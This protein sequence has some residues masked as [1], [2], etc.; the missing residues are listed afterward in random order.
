MFFCYQD[1]SNLGREKRYYRD[2]KRGCF[3]ETQMMRLDKKMDGQNP[4]HKILKNDY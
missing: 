3:I 4:I 2:L 1:S